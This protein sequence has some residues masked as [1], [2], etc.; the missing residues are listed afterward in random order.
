[1]ITTVYVDD[2][3]HQAAA[4]L[5]IVW[6]LEYGRD[7]KIIPFAPEQGDP[8]DDA[9]A[10]LVLGDRTVASPP[11]G[12]DYQIDLVGRWHRHT[13]LPLPWAFWVCR[14]EAC[15]TQ[16]RNRLEFAARQ[17]QS[18]GRALASYVAEDHGWPVDLATREIASNSQYHICC[19]TLDAL[20][21]LTHL[22]ALYGV[23]PAGTPGQ[24][25]QDT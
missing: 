18:C 9:Q 6:G 5:R 25:S 15:D 4:V 1:M 19:C 3:S 12:Y 20:D 10:T 11:L 22:A 14:T 16:L 23:L 24:T 21:E 7:L 17:G 2:N 13:G 8:P